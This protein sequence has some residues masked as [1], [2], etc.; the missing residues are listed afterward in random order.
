MY[1]IFS[2]SPHWYQTSVFNSEWLLKSENETYKKKFK[3]GN[4]QFSKPFTI[5]K[6]SEIKNNDP[7]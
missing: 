4:S 1:K 2:G 7:N 6:A 5:L 3:I